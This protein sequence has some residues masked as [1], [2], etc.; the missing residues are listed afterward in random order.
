MEECVDSKL[1]K[2]IGLSNF[3]SQQIDKILKE[4]KIK[5]SMLQVCVHVLY[6]SYPGVNSPCRLMLW[7]PGLAVPCL[8]AKESQPMPSYRI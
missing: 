6:L 1:T 8:G 7:K 5:P 2:A 3:N 4:G